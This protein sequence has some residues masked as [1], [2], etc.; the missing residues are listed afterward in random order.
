MKLWSKETLV[1]GGLYSV[2]GTPFAYIENNLVEQISS[3]LLII[4]FLFTIALCFNKTPKFI[5]LLINKHPN[6][7]YY[8]A[9][10]G[11]IPYFMIIGFATIFIYVYFN[12]YTE[13]SVTILEKLYIW[14]L[15]LGFPFSLLIAFIRQ[16]LNK[17]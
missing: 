8:L 5:S 1:L 3:G 13:T 2:I 17:F 7:S 14:I 9:S 11:W 15:N 10:F 6:I 4:F 16:K 12:D